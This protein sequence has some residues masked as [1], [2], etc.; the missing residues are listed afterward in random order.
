MGPV[1][2][3][4]VIESVADDQG[5]GSGQVTTRTRCIESE[6]SQ[7]LLSEGARHSHSRVH[8]GVKLTEDEPDLLGEAAVGGSPLDL[9]RRRR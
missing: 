5:M 2:W 3:E 1:L 9:G 8:S 6:N 7:R 4:G